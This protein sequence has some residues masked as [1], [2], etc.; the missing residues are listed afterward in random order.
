MSQSADREHGTVAP[1]AP[2]RL[3]RGFATVGGWTLASRVL[4]FMRDILI[5]AF[6]GSGPVAEAFFVAFRLPNMFRRFFAEGAFNM[7]FIPLFAKK[8]E[9]EG[10]DAARRFGE[11]AMSVLLTALIAL[12]VIAQLA[13]PWFVLALASGFDGSDGGERFDLAVAFSRVVFPYIVFISLA[14]LFSGI[15]N[16]FGRFAAAAAA[17]VL[18]NVVLIAAMLLAHAAGWEVGPT[19]SWAVFVAG[20]AQ[21]ALVALAAGRAGMKL[22]LRM[23]RLTRDVRRLIALGI[24]AALAGGVMQINLLVGT[25]VASY[26]DGAVSWLW[27][28]DRLYQLPL[29]VVGVAIGVVLLPELSRRVRAGD[30]AASAGAMNRAAE[31]SLL[32]T[33]PATV[34]FIALPV[35]ITGVL[36]ERGAFTGADTAATATA[37]TI[38]ALG[39]PAFVLQKVIQPAFFAR[40]DTRTP[41][42]YALVSMVVNIVVA[43][44]GAPVIGY[45]AA[46]L[47]TT[48]AGWVNL[49]LLWRGAQRFGTGVAVD[50]R[51]AHRWPRIL[52]AS[53]VMGAII[54]GLAEAIAAIAPDW[55][56]AGLIVIVA[57]G[58]L[59]FAAAAWTLGAMRPGDLRAA[60]RRTPPDRQVPDR[61]EPD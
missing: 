17:P 39:L 4:G 42:N 15:L 16:S 24:P 47:G 56:I 12:T 35:L 49:A 45:L 10:R 54:L 25:Q 33:L 38:Y 43:V 44:G 27:Y 36:F 14:A 13:M 20:I 8:L 6:L 30:A 29:G 2:I 23:P 3:L 51:L 1:S 37:L 31:F 57:L 9:G 18:L 53:L 26:F 50:E 11:E 58:A 59:S 22:R 61:Q 34:A 32:L 48:L 7:A 60:L 55:R 46:A 21:L 52:G 19:L 28:A 41:L 40:E 5:A